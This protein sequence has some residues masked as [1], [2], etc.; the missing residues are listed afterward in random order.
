M[1]ETPLSFAQQ[2]LRFFD[3]FRP[4]SA[5]GAAFNIV[6]RYRI[7]GPLDVTALDWAT[8]ELVRRHDILRT[9]VHYGDGVPC[10]WAVDVPPLPLDVR[11]LPD[12]DVRAFFDEVDATAFDVSRPPLLR[13]VLA[14]TADDEHLF[15]MACHHSVFDNWSLAIAMRELSTLYAV[16]TEGAEMPPPPRQYAELALWQDQGHDGPTDES[17]AFWEEQL[18]ELPLVMLPLD[19]PRTP[20]AQGERAIHRVEL[21]AEEAEVVVRRVRMARAT[22]FMAVVAAYAWALADVSGQRDVFVPVLT[23]GRYR[24][25][26]EG[27]LGFFI[28]ALPIRVYLHEDLTPTQ[29]LGL[30]QSSCLDA[31]EHQ[32]TPIVRTFEHVPDLAMVL[33]DQSYALTPIQFLELPAGVGPT[34]TTA[35]GEAVCET[36]VRAGEGN[37]Q[38]ELTLPLDGLTTSAMLPDG[39]FVVD[40]VYSTELY[41]EKTIARF[42]EDIRAF[43]LGLAA[44]NAEARS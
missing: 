7:R 27:M 12:P 9:V 2:L 16:A 41:D 25:W 5:S 4:G 39:R 14:T 19:R 31:Y 29:A 28:N 32:Q 38:P 30:V 20:G 8:Q 15:G 35:F 36:V 33:G 10:Q 44:D 6:G 37:Q 24:R 34:T 1:T 22:P 3:L 43:L 26:T 21:S 17:L 40:F 42:G 18:G 11:S 23:N 13:A